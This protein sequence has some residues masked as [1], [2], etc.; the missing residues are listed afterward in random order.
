MGAKRDDGPDNKNPG[1][2]D[3][4]PED[5]MTHEK[6]PQWKFSDNPNGNH[7]GPFVNP[8]NLGPG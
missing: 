4:K 1:P 6:A 3:Y 8:N 5:G 7:N 2:A